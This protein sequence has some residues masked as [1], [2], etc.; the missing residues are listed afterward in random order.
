MP[1]G[2]GSSP[3]WPRA[4][5]GQ[6]RASVRSPRWQP[7]TITETLLALFDQAEACADRYVCP[8]LDQLRTRAEQP[9]EL[10]VL[11]VAFNI[12]TDPK[13]DT[14]ERRFKMA[15]AV[16]R[17]WAAAR[18]TEGHRLEAGDQRELRAQVM[19]LLSRTDNAVPAHGFVEYLDDAREIFQREA[20]DPG[21]CNDEVNS[22]I[23][24]LRDRENDLATVKA[25]LSSTQERPMMAGALLLDALDHAE[26]NVIDEVAVLLAFA[27][28]PDTAPDAARLVLAH[29]AAHDDPAF[30]PVIRELVRHADPAVRAQAASPPEPLAQCFLRDRDRRRDADL[31]ATAASDHTL[32]VVV[33]GLAVDTVYYYRFTDGAEAINARTAPHGGAGRRRRRRRRA[34]PLRPGQPRPSAQPPGTSPALAGV[35]LSPIVFLLP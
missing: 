14:F 21:R 10:R 25:W 7:L 35:S 5:N 29:A 17:A 19:R 23:R 12:M 22:A 9:G 34:G 4:A 16:A 15:S 3:C 11:Q 8:P 33:T 13:V 6:S 32:R 31:T 2:S 28:R 27:R 24:G 1:S 30:A 18:T 20:L 26:I